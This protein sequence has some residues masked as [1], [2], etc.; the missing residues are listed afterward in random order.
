[1]ISAANLAKKAT[2]SSFVNV[3]VQLSAFNLPPRVRSQRRAAPGRRSGRDGRNPNQA[4]PPAKCH[5]CRNGRQRICEVRCA[6]CWLDSNLHKILG[7]YLLDGDLTLRRTRSPKAQ[8]HRMLGRWAVTSE[9]PARLIV[10]LFAGTAREGGS[11]AK[12]KD[13]KGIDNPFPVDVM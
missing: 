5:S 6:I 2:K 13:F 11:S 1:M 9:K 3:Q 12:A 8:R 4:A 7:S 10:Q